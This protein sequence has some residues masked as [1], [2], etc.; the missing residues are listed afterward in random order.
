MSHNLTQTFGQSAGKCS[1]EAQPAIALDRLRWALNSN[2]AIE[3]PQIQ[4][5]VDGLLQPSPTKTE[6]GDR[7]MRPGFGV[8]CAWKLPR[9]E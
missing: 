7:E 9:R 3:Q 2:L 5:P 8:K 6:R 4:D 1:V